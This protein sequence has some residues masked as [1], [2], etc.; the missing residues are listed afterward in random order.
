M[1][2]AR[3]VLQALVGEWSLAIVLP[4]EER[5]AELPDIGARNAWEWMGDSGL[6]VQRWSVP[7]DEAPDGLAVIGWD[8][9]RATFL[10]H[11]FDD[12]GVVRVYELTL[13]DGVL[14]LERTRADFSPLHFS[15]RYVGT[16]TEDGRRIDGAWFIAH[17][18][19]TWEKDF[20]LIY[21][22]VEVT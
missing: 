8:E 19:E 17:D 9:G 18:H 14:T 1:P 7:V 2:D 6:L 10:Q 13:V 21:T 22:R 15:Q 11:Y 5:P 12:R 16:L 3:D 4:G 20:D